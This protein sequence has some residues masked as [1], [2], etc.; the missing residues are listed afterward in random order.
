M[1]HFHTTALIRGKGQMAQKVVGLRAAEFEAPNER[2]PE[3]NRQITK[4]ANDRKEVQATTSGKDFELM[5]RQKPGLRAQPRWASGPRTARGKQRSKY[6][7]VKHGIFAKVVLPGESRPEYESLVKDLL[8]DLSPHGRLEEILVE[9]IAMLFWC[10][11]RLIEAMNAE[12]QRR[13]EFLEWDEEENRKFPSLEEL[14]VLEV[15]PTQLIDHIKEHPKILERCLSLLFALKAR[16]L[17]RGF[18]KEFSI[19]V[20]TTIYGINSPIRT[21][22]DSYSV[23]YPTSQVSEEER[24]RMGYASPAVCKERFLEDID[25]EIARLLKYQEKQ[26][27]VISKRLGL[28]GTGLRVPQAPDLDRF[29]RY[30]T[31][32]ER[33]LDRT[34]SQLERLQRMRL[35]H[36]VPPPLQ[37]NVSSNDMPVTT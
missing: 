17:I 35:G 1:L 34:L 33:T 2:S 7:A 29:L 10:L 30:H 22:L 18:N 19:E 5:S 11:R 32:F 15:G 36:P 23:W 20:L 13:T 12:T 9:K 21:L 24:Q 27:S 3:M 31:T 14:H 37:V 26:K 4:E 16:L 6:N 8:E 25:D 28:A